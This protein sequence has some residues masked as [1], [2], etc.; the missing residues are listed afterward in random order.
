MS[1]ADR[2]EV[3][4]TVRRVVDK[5]LH[6]PTVQ[7]KK[8]STRADSARGGAVN[9]ADAL[10]ELFNLQV[11]TSAAVSQVIEPGDAGKAR[12]ANVL[13]QGGDAAGA[14][15]TGATATGTT[16]ATGTAGTT[17]TGTGTTGTT[18]GEAEAS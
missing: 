18:T 9:Y 3:E 5:L 15:T 8:L 12:I 13:T 14:G 6:A 16:G 11:G 7:V 10:A 2:H 1:D 4:R 17:A